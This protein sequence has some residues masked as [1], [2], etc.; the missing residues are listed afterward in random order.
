MAF[1]AQIHLLRRL[2]AEVESVDSVSSVINETAVIKTRHT[3]QGGML[4]VALIFD[5]S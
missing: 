3:S 5:I 1:S 2:P 4:D